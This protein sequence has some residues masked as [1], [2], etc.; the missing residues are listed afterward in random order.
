V[1]Q[2]A[3]SRRGGRSCKCEQMQRIL[4]AQ[5]RIIR[6]FGDEGCPVAATQAGI[7]H[8]TQLGT[9]IQFLHAALHG[10]GQPQRAPNLMQPAKQGV[11][12]VRVLK[13]AK[14]LGL[15]GCSRM[16]AKSKYDAL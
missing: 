15:E 7:G 10:S 14:S 3:T 9:A 13:E 12:V 5:A 16:T 6:A 1:Q 11:S 4:A 2:A 8:C